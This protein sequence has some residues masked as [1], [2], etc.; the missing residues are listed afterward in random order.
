MSRDLAWLDGLPAEDAVRELRTCCASAAWARAVAAGRPFADRGA[1]HAAAAAAFEDLG[2]PDIQEALQAHP[3]IGDR[4]AG[5]DR[6]S[7]WS[8]GEQ[9]TARDADAA[10]LLEWNVAYEERFGRVFLICATGLAGE[11]ILHALQERLRTDEATERR[12]TRGELLKIA[13]LRLDKL[14][15]GAGL[16]V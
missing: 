11:E 8:R 16:S 3:R 9:S 5:P 4:P 7:R 10:A 14:L 15:D 2:W 6:E 12:V 1:L 13:Q